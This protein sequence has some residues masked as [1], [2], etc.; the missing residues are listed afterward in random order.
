ML[1]S[2]RHSFNL[3]VTSGIGISNGGDAGFGDSTAN[4]AALIAG[5]ILVGIGMSFCYS[6]GVHEVRVMPQDS[7]LHVTTSA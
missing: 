3:A 1:P 6:A 5:I 4:I 2:I 7:A